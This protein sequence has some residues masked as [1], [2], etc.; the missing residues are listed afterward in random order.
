MNAMEA[1]QAG[2]GLE[3]ILADVHMRIVAEE[4]AN[5]FANSNFERLRRKGRH[6]FFQLNLLGPFT[7]TFKQF[8]SM[9]NSHNIIEYSTK[10]ADGS[11]TQKQRD[12]LVRHG[13]GER[14]A[15]LIDSQREENIQI[16]D[17][18]AYEDAKFLQTQSVHR[19]L[20]EAL[21]QDESKLY[22]RSIYIGSKLKR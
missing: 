9:A 15:K 11:I 18:V 14:E 20:N 6:V 22:T 7:R 8:S 16:T 2:E 1:Q 17:R 19:Q 10:W 12:F 4:T 21:N 5:P 3:T 13:I